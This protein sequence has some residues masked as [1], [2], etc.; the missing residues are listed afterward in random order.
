MGEQVLDGDPLG[1]GR[2]GGPARQ[3]RIQGEL[4]LLY[5]LQD[6]RGGLSAEVQDRGVVA[7]VAV[8]T[9]LAVHHVGDPV[10]TPAGAHKI[11]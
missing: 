7:G 6:H 11:P 1:V 10:V 3:W 8:D 4:T 5:E 2:V 9:V